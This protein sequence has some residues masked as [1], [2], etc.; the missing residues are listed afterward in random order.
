[1]KKLY[2][3]VVFLSLTY[4]IISHAQ[5]IYSDGALISINSGAL[6]H[7][8]GGVELTNTTLTNN[9]IL[10]ITKNSTFPNTGTFKILAGT[11]V[12]GNGIYSVEQNWI[13]DAIFTAGT[14]EVR[15]NGNTEQLITSNNGTI[16]EFHNLVLSG[17]GTG[18]D[19]R[20]SL[21]NVGARIAPN[22]QLNL[23][24]RELNGG[25]NNLEVLNPSN[26]AIINN[27]TMNNEGFIS[28]LIPAAIQ[29]STNT[30][31][32]YI[33][34]VGSSDGTLRYR[35][36]LIQPGSSLNSIY[37]VRMNNYSAD[38]DSYLGSSKEAAI[39]ATNT[40]FYHSIDLV[41]GEPEVNV[42][43]AYNALSDGEYNG[44]AHWTLPDNIWQEVPN[45][46]ENILG[47]YQS[48]LKEQWVFNNDG[49]PYIL[50]TSGEF[51][52]IPNVF[53]PNG[54]GVNDFYFINLKGID[55]MTL[56][57]VNRW[58]ELVYK[59]DDINGKWDGTFNGNMC[60]DGV[61]FYILNAKSKTQNYQKHGHITLNAN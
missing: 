37:S 16:T 29:W 19:R 55:E 38:L 12:S 2:L 43:I 35:P 58:G 1:M 57:I 34:P 22:G 10:T 13:N 41:A 45:T 42:A 46:I 24:N 49:E 61:Y 30:T 51:I 33:F 48:M 8:N 26:S 54:D 32:K 5:I 44:I 23:T 7:C 3:L 14:S 18:I 28:H 53:T 11:Q 15:L 60:S 17:V 27:T 6:V 25:T 21:V 52:E 39:E 9:G 4:T 40:L 36:V 47:N 50:S 59:S 20:K 31:N 56:T